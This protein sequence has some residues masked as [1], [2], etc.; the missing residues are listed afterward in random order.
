MTEAVKP[1]ESARSSDDRA[2]RIGLWIRRAAMCLLTAVVGIALANVVGQRATIAHASSPRADLTVR[3]PDTVRPGLL[4]QAKISVT[5][6]DA[7]PNAQVVLSSGWLDGMTINTIEPSPSTERSGPGGS[8]VFDLGALQPGQTWVE[9]IEYQVNPTS[10]SRR[11][12]TI[13]VLSNTAP[14]VDLQRTMTVIP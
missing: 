6:H 2:G 5:A 8:L 7:L 14:V 4:F 3:A 13:T 11:H 10:I 12:Q 1:I 9:Y